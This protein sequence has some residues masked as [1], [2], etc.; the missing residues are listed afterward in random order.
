[1]IYRDFK[2][3]KLSGLGFGAMRLPL[4][5]DGKTVDAP[6]VEKMFDKAIASGVNYFDTAAPYHGGTSETVVGE[7]LEKYPRG[8]WFLASKYPGHQHS[9]V[10]TPAETFA[11]QLRKC[12]TDHF[13][14]YLFHNIC[15][16]SIDDYLDPRW[17]MLEYFVEQRKEG[18]IRHLGFSTHATPEMLREILDG[19]YGREMEFC[20]I[21]LNWLDWKLQ[22]ADEKVAI[23]AERGIPVWVMEP[24]RGGMLVPYGVE[25]SFRWL[26]DIPGVNMILSGMSNLQQ[27]EDN[28]AIFSDPEPLDA[29]EKAALQEIASGLR[30]AAPCTRCRYCCDGCPAGL[31]IPA[32]MECWNDLSLGY[33]NA[34]M[35][36]LE[37]LEAEKRPSACLACGACR[38]ICP[39]G[40]N[41]PEALSGLSALFDKYPKWAD[42]C[43][44][45]N[46]LAAAEY[47]RTGRL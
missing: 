39:Q 2:G 35:M 11:K 4:M 45:R 33:N 20:Q 40:I 21:Q 44:E 19:P 37:S 27:V 32:L 42:I 7:I 14:Y 1:M 30:S 9:E 24:V 12:R 47:L 3:E 18:R 17:G 34:Q 10:F 26:L 16:N 13:D 31:D 41:I 36:F 43:V 25:R 38:K 29:A 6:L 5:E 28:L 23:L 22:R 8:S 15:E 46:R